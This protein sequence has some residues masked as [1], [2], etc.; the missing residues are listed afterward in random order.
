MGGSAGNVQALPHLLAAGVPGAGRDVGAAALGHR[1]CSG[2]TR[3]GNTL[4]ACQLGR[5]LAIGQNFCTGHGP[6][7]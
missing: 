2:R 3:S 7:H 6:Q 1:T 5:H 4:L